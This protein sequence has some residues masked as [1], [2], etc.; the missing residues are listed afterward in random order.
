MSYV[1]TVAN[2]KTSSAPY[3]TGRKNIP[4]CDAYKIPYLHLTAAGLC[5]IWAC[6]LVAGPTEAIYRH[7]NL[8][9]KARR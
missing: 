1:H 3:A 8:T 7:S 2:V 5:W 4:K 9:A 6:P